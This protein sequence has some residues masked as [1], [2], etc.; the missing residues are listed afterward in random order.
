MYSQKQIQKSTSRTNRSGIFT[1]HT[2]ADRCSAATP[3]FAAPTGSS[4]RIKDCREKSK[5]VNHNKDDTDGDETW[6]IRTR[7]GACARATEEQYVSG[8]TSQGMLTYF[9][10][11]GV[12]GERTHLRQRLQLHFQHVQLRRQG[13]C[14]SMI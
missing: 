8:D 3:S 6:S 1:K 13:Q 10:L 7:G 14:D 4:P 11:Q 9:S 12:D 2:C 5:Q